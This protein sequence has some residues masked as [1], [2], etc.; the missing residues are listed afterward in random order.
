MKVEL[1]IVSALA[2]GLARGGESFEAETGAAEGLYEEGGSE[3][4]LLELIHDVFNAERSLLVSEAAEHPKIV[5]C[6][7]Q[8][9][10][11]PAALLSAFHVD[12]DMDPGHFTL[13][14]RRW[15]P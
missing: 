1:D 5:A 7:R 13:P 11:A 9:R 6:G 4:K 10:L 2:D 12:G 3:S 14:P 8:Y 15:H